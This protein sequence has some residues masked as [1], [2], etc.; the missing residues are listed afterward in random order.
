[1]CKNEA[2]TSWS[3]ENKRKLCLSNVR[4][5]RAMFT[6]GALKQFSNID[7]LLTILKIKKK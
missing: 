5:S 7:C 3:E 6:L 2:I 4:V 1:M